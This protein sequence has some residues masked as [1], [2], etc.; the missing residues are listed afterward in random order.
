MLNYADGVVLEVNS[1]CQRFFGIEVNKLK[2]KPF[3]DLTLSND[4]DCNWEHLQ[5]AVR[6][7][8]G[9]VREG[10]HV[11]MA[12]GALQRVNLSA[13]LLHSKNQRRVLVIL[14][15]ASAP[16][17]RK[18]H[19]NELARY[20]TVG[21]YR[22]DA[23]GRLTHVNQ[24]LAE[25]LGYESPE[26][27]LQSDGVLRKNWH[28]D[29]GV[30]TG[31]IDGAHGELQR[32]VQIRR[33]DGSASWVLET[34]RTVGEGQADAGRVGTLREISEEMA[35]EDAL[36]V[37]EDKYRSLVEHS[38]DGVFVIRDGVYVF[39]NKV[40]AAMLGY[41]PD[42]MIGES[43]LR[44][45]A[46]EDRQKIVDMWHERQAGHWE[47]ETYEAHLLKKDGETRVLVSVRSGPIH[48]AGEM[49]ST[50]TV[51]DITAYRKTEQRLSLVEQ[52][53]QDI[54][55][56][57]VVG[58]YQSTSDGRLLAANPALARIL[59]Y[60]SVTELRREVRNVRTVYLH[61]DDRDAY[62]EK[63]EAEGQVQGAELR[64]R[65]RDGTELW[66]QD[67]A[68]A[69]YDKSGKLLFY[70]G[71]MADI[72]ARK[73]VEQAL[74]RSEQLFRTLV[75]NTH[76]GI[77]MQRDGVVSYANRA[78]AHMLDY[79]ESELTGRRLS[80]IFAPEAVDILN[81]LGRE[82]ESDTEPR[83]YETAL[84]AADG[85][86]RVRANLS[87]ATVLLA[88][89]PVTIITVQDLTREKR[90]E[91]R[92]RRLA[93]HDPLTDLPN[94]MV[95]RERLVETLAHTHETGQTDWAV[96]FLDLD[97]FKLVND[98]LGHAAGDELLGQVATRLCKV[99]RSEDLVC[100]HG[101]DEFVILASD[102]PHEIDA[103]ELAERIEAAMAQ[104]F[105]IDEHEIYNQATIG[106]ALGRREY[107][108]PEEV[109]RDA[110]SA[111]AAGKRL[112]KVCHVVFSSSMH[113]AAM[114]RLELETTLRAGLSRGEFDC[115]YQPIVNASTN[116][117][118][119]FEALLRWRHPEQGLLNPDAFLQVAEESGVIVP[120][121]WL[122]LRNALEACRTWQD[123]GPGIPVGVA[124]NLSDAQFRLPQ[125]PEYIARE[126]EQARL[127]PELLHLEVTE[128]VFLETP[129]LARRML[130][131]LHALGVKLYLDDFGTGYSA[132]SYLRQL[133][134]DALKIDRSFVE[135]LPGDARTTAIVR[136]IVSLARDLDLAV[137]AEGIERHEQVE[138]LTEMGCH[139][140]QGFLFG[141]PMSFAESKNFIDS[142]VDRE[143][144][145][146]TGRA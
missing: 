4:T 36:A 83:V 133:P 98:S 2:G 144:L 20:A 38:Q 86:R 56:H 19:E 90:A 53:Y 13:E 63:L 107:N 111:V 141:K 81:R 28:L 67:S 88:E 33:V 71:M 110:D 8:G 120:L 46:P 109:L 82:R 61:G 131:R 91:A 139:L 62:L 96:L 41:S 112:G 93:T 99:V 21:L 79:S 101:G 64:L 52:R 105:R 129:A 76:I 119:S 45:F 73:L 35:A 43:F 128:R 15:P 59:G 78:A 132:L 69:V 66:V 68:R 77:F 118:E 51:R 5:K 121:G 87:V 142:A 32:K 10:V 122:G 16:V 89:T 11:R 54:F 29:A 39:V 102:I 18:D 115:H 138:I 97:A 85:M 94:R 31:E 108:M 95:L 1:A 140:F 34:V 113:I 135:A 25:M 3:S 146:T 136:N 134:F 40:Y 80:A 70:E 30:V 6:L 9:F 42:E 114:E 49:A 37:S 55:E 145:Q 17:V 104:P 23:E 50:G 84:L 92:L 125:L 7:E 12:A 74:H 127:P 44:F 26:Q 57:A 100:H 65:H 143:V 130:G 60:E 117:V 58:I 116:R 103:V 75:E 22:V 27:L 137:V 72:T 126:L 47:K 14:K 124:V 106:I 48:F 123:F 24:A